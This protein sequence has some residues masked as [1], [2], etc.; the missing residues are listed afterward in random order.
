M[1]WRN[2][3]PQTVRPQRDRRSSTPCQ[4]YAQGRCRNGN[5]CPFSHAEGD[6]SAVA[7]TQALVAAVPSQALVAAQAA[8]AGL[9]ILGHPVDTTPQVD[10]RSKIPCR[11]HLRGGC[12]NSDKCPFSHDVPKEVPRTTVGTQDDSRPETWCRELRGALASFGDGAVVTKLSFPSDFSA[13]RI[14]HLPRG[15]STSS[16]VATLASL[17]FVVGQD[18][19]RVLPVGDETHCTAHVRVEDPQFAKRL[20]DVLADR[21]NDG[22]RA[23]P[24][25]AP[26]PQTTNNR[27][28]DSKKV[29]CSWH[30]PT[31]TAWLNFSNEGI[32]AKV[33]SRFTSGIY[34]VLDQRVQCD[35]PT[36]GNGVR[37]H[38]AWTFKLS[39]LP[40][41]AK[42]S[43]VTRSIPQVFLPRHVE[44]SQAP[45]DLD[46]PTANAMIESILLQAGQLELWEGSPEGTGKRYKAKAWFMNDA[47][48][49]QAVV[50][51]ND[52]PLPFNKNGKLTVQLVHS[53]KLKISADVY[54]A[55]EQEIVAH[56][57]E[58]KAQHLVYR[59]YPPAHGFRVLKIEGGLAKD[60][61]AA[62]KTLERIL[63]GEVVKNDDGAVWAPSF[64]AN[65]R[66]YQQ[67]KQLERDLGI[68]IVRDKRRSQLR[69]MGPALS[70]AV[71][72]AAIVELA[73][74]DSS[75]IFTIE[76]DA[77]QLSRAFK[78]GFR[79]VAA[80]IGHDKVTFDI[81]SSP[82]CIRVVGSE[83]DF[84]LA[85]EILEG[86]QPAPKTTPESTSTSDCAICWTEAE[87][88]VHTPCK[89]VYCAGCFED[90]CLAGVNADGRVRCQG[91]A[92]RC[93]AVLPPG[94]L[95]AHLASATLEDILEASFATYVA[96]HL[97]DLR[98]CPTPDCGQ[99]YRAA[100]PPG[101]SVGSGPLFT[102]PACLAAVCR[103]CNVAHDGMSCAEQ[104]D[105]A[106]GGHEAL[107]AAKRKL[108]IRDCPKCGIGIEKSFGCNHMSC[109]CGAHIC[110]VCLKT[111]ATGGPVYDHMQREHGGIGIGYFPDLG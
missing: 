2:R 83:A 10:S 65:G 105:K 76:L 42:E 21:R 14:S 13:V 70:R 16:V 85:Q 81:A 55:A 35:G 92:G 51:F 97:D 20:C 29:Y 89:H 31:R 60:V 107:A 50:M 98:Y 87:D 52:G 63:D 33:G 103:A 12:S 78:G 57:Q 74:A 75:S 45:Y 48:A 59:A 44:M 56:E 54:D 36:R 23:V 22:L 94:E 66:A 96:R 91:D 18:R 106:S 88:P 110:W 24:I 109:P 64:S 99:M 28:V 6:Q 82:K 86:R 27:R 102:C 25:N 58:W 7:P 79:A 40:G 108:G 100:E 77:Q 46:L 95:Q 17:G 9:T 111:F 104:R 49:R 80:A 47:D 39:D 90:L 26:M 67:M 101:G 37:N 3:L 11:F 93:V 19:V 30:K 1:E 62:K 71:A 38:L 68:V 8:V 84:A 43:D 32:A 5:S 69:L 15:T 72:R 34:K 41:P 61:A 4:F 73:K 53:A